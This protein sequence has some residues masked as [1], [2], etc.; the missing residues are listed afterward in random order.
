MF[1]YLSFHIS[2]IYISSMKEIWKRVLGFEW[3]EVSN[4]GNV[5][6]V[7]R[8]FVNNIGRKCFL[9]GSVIKPKVERGYI[10]FGIR[11]SNHKKIMVSGH[12]LV[13][14]TFIPNPYNFETVNHINGI[15]TD[16]RVENLEWCSIQD[17]IR[18]AYVNNLG[19]YQEKSNEKINNINLQNS[20]K[21]ID[22]ICPDG[23]EKHFNSVK[24]ISSYFGIKQTTI[25]D[26]LLKQHHRAFG[27]TFIG[28]KE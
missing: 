4:Y 11:D 28:Y 7:D 24:E 15:K 19:H 21:R 13:A 14:M 25:N 22:V 8:E 5:R 18:H 26:A 12:R 17:N 6:S 16:N 9:K 1:P 27:Y 10:R 20:Y 2:I 3:Y 23:T